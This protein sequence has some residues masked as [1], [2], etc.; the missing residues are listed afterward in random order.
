VLPEPM[1]HPRSLAQAPFGRAPFGYAQ[2]RR[3]RGA[4]MGHPGG[5]CAARLKS[6]PDEPRPDKS[7]LTRDPDIYE[8]RVRLPEGCLR[9]INYMGLIL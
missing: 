8:R 5:R 9:S 2:D 6:C 1:T 7:S 3:D 4:R